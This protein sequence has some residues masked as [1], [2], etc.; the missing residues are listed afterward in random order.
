MV[1][2]IFLD[3]YKVITVP[4]WPFKGQF[5]YEEVFAMYGFKYGNYIVITDFVSLPNAHPDPRG[6]FVVLK[7][8]LASA[9]PASSGRLIGFAHR[10]PPGLTRPSMGDIRGIPSHYV[11]AVWCEGH[12]EWYSWL[13]RKKAIYLS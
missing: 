1:R 5:N 6:K 7:S 13:G 9:P 11:G 12:V 10:H 2:V 8:D 4:K 3:V